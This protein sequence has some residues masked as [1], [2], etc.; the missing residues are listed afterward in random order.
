MNV[1]AVVKTAIKAAAPVVKKSL[2]VVVGMISGGVGAYGKL[3]AGAEMADMKQRL[4]DLEAL[5]K[6]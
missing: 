2:P 4:E 3:K 6:K 5:V 1:F